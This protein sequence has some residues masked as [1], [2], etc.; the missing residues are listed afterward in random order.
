M[1]SPRDAP[2]RWKGSSAAGSPVGKDSG[3]AGVCWPTHCAT[4]DAQHRIISTENLSGYSTSNFSSNGSKLGVLPIPG[5]ESQMLSEQLTE[6]KKQMDMLASSQAELQ[7]TVQN[8][9]KDI[10]DLLS[11]ESN[12]A[13]GRHFK[14]TSRPSKTRVSSKGLAVNGEHVNAADIIKQ[15]HRDQETGIR[16]TQLIAMFQKADEAEAADLRKQQND[17]QHWN[18]KTMR[19]LNEYTSSVAQMEVLIDAIMG[20][21]ILV[22]AIFMGISMDHSDGTAVWLFFDVTFS[23]LFVSELLI[24]FYLHGVIYHFTGTGKFANTFDAVLILA[25]VVQVSLEMFGSNHRSSSDDEGLPSASLFRM[26]R[27]FKLTRLVRVLKSDMFKDLANMIHGILAGIYTLFW[28][29]MMFLVIVYV[30]SLVFREVLGRRQIENVF[31]YFNNVPRSM[32][33]TFRC[34]FGDCATISGSPIFEH[35]AEAYGGTG[36]A[37]SIFYVMFIFI[38]SIVL[39]NV[40]S[41][42][43][44]E[45]TMVAAQELRD[46]RRRLRMQDKLLEYSRVSIFIRRILHYSPD[47]REPKML[48]EAVEEIVHAEVSREI[49]DHVVKDPEAKQALED[50]DI[51]VLDHG[52]LSDIF[53]PD[54]GGTVNVMDIA[55]G[56]RRLRGEA[57]QSDI[58]CIDL[59]IRSM[60]EKIGAMN[61]MMTFLCGGGGEEAAITQ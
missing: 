27:L 7:T 38:S 37:M 47:H 36:V 43:F 4:G 46:E 12:S 5:S 33:T 42:M 10:T 31:E 34:S 52:R 54:N 2:P 1:P 8:M 59:M 50:L 55:Q 40:I 45:S 20:V 53:D 3:S 13:P 28:S 30:V 48:S 56:I 22:N 18:E 24:K 29:I 21:V 19:F 11:K 9:W 58:V 57:R 60:Q 25:D 6:V 61:E 14:P 44:V 32:Y 35:V 23:V 39:F 15:Q 49:I 51:S 17:K 26:V 41:A 16:T